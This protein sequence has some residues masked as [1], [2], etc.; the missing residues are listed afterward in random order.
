MRG[1]GGESTDRPEITSV[2]RRRKSCGA[3]GA[4]DRLPRLRGCA[5]SAPLRLG[6]S[7][8]TSSDTGALLGQQASTRLSGGPGHVELA[9]A[10][11]GTAAAGS[12]H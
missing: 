1:G 12:P 8:R 2:P 6:L 9:S 3:R 5:A 7:A 4:N 10:I 11:P